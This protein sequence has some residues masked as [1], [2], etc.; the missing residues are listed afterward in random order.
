MTELEA[1]RRT[2]EDFR[3]ADT[4]L[5][6]TLPATLG[7]R[8]LAQRY[9]RLNSPDDLAAWCVA[10]GLLST[11]PSVTKTQL[12]EAKRLREAI[13]DVGEALVVGSTPKS[14]DVNLINQ[15]ARRPTVAPS[16]AK[17]ATG[18]VWKGDDVE[19]VLALIARDAIMA[20]AEA[21]RDR[22][23]MCE[24]PTCR[25]LFID[26]SRPGKRRWCSMTTCGDHEK[27]ARFRGKTVE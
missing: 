24:S 16:L 22:L 8:G 2:K 3:F 15:W 10:S 14:A 25:G 11:K 23:R 12:A 20:Y 21:P 19:Q 6:F 27:K 1:R 5:C 18:Y 26:T 9:E 4:R 7:D 13:Q 17:D